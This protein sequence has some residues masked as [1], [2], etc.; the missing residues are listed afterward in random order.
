MSSAREYFQ[1]R[2]TFRKQIDS[3]VAQKSISFRPPSDS[4]D[5]LAKRLQAIPGIEKITLS[6][7]KFSHLRSQSR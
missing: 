1:S 6:E 5:N 2:A 7:S 3:D 4:M